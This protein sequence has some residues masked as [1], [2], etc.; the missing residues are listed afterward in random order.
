VLWLIY[1]SKPND[2]R[3]SNLIS[4][5]SFCISPFMQT[6]YLLLGINVFDVC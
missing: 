3:C 6:C 2:G 4:V 5:D 1:L